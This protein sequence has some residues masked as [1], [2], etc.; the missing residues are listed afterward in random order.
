M[1]WSTRELA[2]LEPARLRE[3]PRYLEGAV[4]RL[5]ALPA[6]ATRDRQ[7]M[8]TLDR[9]YA[10]Y[11]RLLQGLPEPRRGS[12]EVVDVAWLFEEL[13]ISLFAQRLGTPFPISEQRI[14]KAIK[15]IR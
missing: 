9:V 14:M 4:V 10:A 1:P 11:D 7:A 8:A 15:A 5:D 2:E 12:P 3:V 6:S 13:R